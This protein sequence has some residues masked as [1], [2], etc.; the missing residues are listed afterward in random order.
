[1]ASARARNRLDVRG[2]KLL[3]ACPSSCSGALADL[4]F[5]ILVHVL[6]LEVLLPGD[7]IQTLDLALE[8]VVIEGLPQRRLQLVVVPRLGDQPI[9]L[10]PIDGLDRDVH[11]G[12]P[13]EHHADHVR[14][15]I[16]DIREEIHAAHLRH[17]LIGDHHLRGASLEQ[18]ECFLGA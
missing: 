8:V 12:V 14:V 3:C 7:L 11:L 1:M 2:A 4:G 13:G 10:A 9:D 16:A 5:E 6:E 18:V 15:S 17:A